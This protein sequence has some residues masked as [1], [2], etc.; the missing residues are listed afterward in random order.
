MTIEGRG[1]G[2]RVEGRCALQCG[3]PSE[4]FRWEGAARRHNI[5]TYYL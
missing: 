1:R 4:A 3:P 5:L 2:R